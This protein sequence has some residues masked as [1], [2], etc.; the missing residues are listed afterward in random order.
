MKRFL[1]A[2][3]LSG[4]AWWFAMA[5]PASA[6]SNGVKMGTAPSW[7]AYV[8]T[9]SR[10]LVFQKTESSCT[11]EVIAPQW[12]LTAAHCVVTE[13]AEGEPVSAGGA[14]AIAATHEATHKE[15]TAG[16]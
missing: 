11:G 3:S 13:D 16:E 6:V 4:L 10:I 12:I 8:T 15:G 1:K 2:I 5:A 9:T 7:I 14:Q